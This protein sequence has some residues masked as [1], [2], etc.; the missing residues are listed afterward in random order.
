MESIGIGYLFTVFG[1]GIL[2]FFSPCIL[3]VLPVYASYLIADRPAHEV[4]L[5]KR[6]IQSLAFTAGLSVVFFIMGLG[7]GALGGL[8]NNSYF[9]IACGIIVFIF[10]L[11]YTGLISI[12]FLDREKRLL[13]K[14]DKKK[15]TLLSAFFLGFVFSFAWTPCVGPILGT[16]LALSAQQGGALL[17]GILL[18]AYS[19]GLGIPFMV[20]TLGSEFFFTKIKRISKHLPKIQIIGGVLIAVLGLYMIFSQVFSLE[21]ESTTNHTS[22]RTQSEQSAGTAAE[23]ID[24]SLVDLE[25]NTVTLSDY[26]GKP[27]YLKFWT[28][29]CPVC[30]SGMD[31]Y[32]E[33]SAEYNEGDDLAVLS[34]VTPDI[35]SEMDEE[36]FIAWAHS[37]DLTFPILF[38]TD[39]TL[40]SELNVRGYPTSVFIDKE[41]VISQSRTGEVARDELKAILDSMIDA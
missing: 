18:L 20:L 7:A 14:E 25:G 3:P 26:R 4:S 15:G 32:K 31:D 27:V 13:V 28:T 35:G 9:F 10:G 36:S 11:Y 40:T 23:A 33:I 12:P 22:E 5:V 41:G 37:Q 39:G 34:V 30:L 19:L 2:S 6:L 16:V 21:T 1:A 8:I 38:D 24:F 17:G 29:W